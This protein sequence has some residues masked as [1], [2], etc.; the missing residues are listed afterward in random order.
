MGSKNRINL[1][2]TTAETDGRSEE[3]VPVSGW[4]SAESIRSRRGWLEQTGGMRKM[5]VAVAVQTVNHVTTPDAST[6]IRTL[7]VWTTD[8]PDR[9]PEHGVTTWA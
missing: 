7:V 2:D 8:R 3:Y 4:M 9:K 1:P 5:S 6:K